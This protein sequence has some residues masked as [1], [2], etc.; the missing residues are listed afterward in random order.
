MGVFDGLN[1]Y[2]R[3]LAAQQRSQGY[4]SLAQQFP[5]GTQFPRV[6]YVAVSERFRAATPVAY[7]ATLGLL[8]ED[9]YAI[10]PRHA[11][12]IVTGYEVIYRDRPEYERGRTAWQSQVG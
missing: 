5:P 1:Q 12:D 11:H 4:E 9:T 6:D 2:A 7:I 8:P 3:D 10:V